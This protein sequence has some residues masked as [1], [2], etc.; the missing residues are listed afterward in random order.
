MARYSLRLTAPDGNYPFNIVRVTLTRNGGQSVWNATFTPLARTLDRAF[1]LDNGNWVLKVSG[2]GFIPVEE[3]FQVTGPDINKAVS[4]AVAYFTL[5]TDRDR[6]GVV[7]PD[8]GPINRSNPPAITFGTAGVGAIIPVNCNSD[9]SNTA[10]GYADNQDKN[11]NGNNDRDHDIAHMQIKLV[12]VGANDPISPDWK[13]RL[14][15]KN[16]GI[17]T[18]PPQQHFRVFNGIANNSTEILG[19]ETDFETEIKANTLGATKSYGIEAVRFAGN[20]FRRGDGHIALEVIQ[21]EVTGP[22]VRSYWFSEK[23]VAARWIGNHHLQTP[24]DLYVAD[25]GNLAFRTALGAVAL[26]DGVTVNLADPENATPTGVP[27]LDVN[28]WRDDPDSPLANDDDRWLR[29]TIVSG[30]TAWPGNNGAVEEKQVFMKT[31]RLRP[32]QNWVY[33]TLLSASVGVTYPAAGSRNDHLN[34]GNSGGNIGVTPPVKK[35]TNAGTTEYLYGRI[36]YGD[37]VYS[38]VNFS[39]RAFF[40]A[41]NMQAAIALDTDWLSVGHVD[42]MMTFVPYAAGANAFKKWKLLIASPKAAYDLMT[43]NQGAHGA[44]KVMQRPAWNTGTS[45]FGYT[46][47]RIGGTSVACTINDLLGNGNAPLANP[48]GSGAYTYAQLRNWNLNGIEQVIGRNVSLL[49]DAFDLDDSDIIRVPVIFYPCHQ[50]DENRPT[51][52][53]DFI[54]WRVGG[55][56]HGFN[57]FPGKNNGFRTGALTA[58]MPNMFVGN[59]RLYVPKPFGPWIEA[60]GHDMAAARDEDKNGY[61]L[62]EQDLKTKLATA[63]VTHTCV[64][65]DDWNDYHVAHG[66]IHCGTNE[67]RTPYDGQTAFGAARYEDWWTAVDA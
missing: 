36:Y 64:F 11:V 9:G 65:I 50:I 44:A 46:N 31:F 25:A 3:A 62:F 28:T 38:R 4:L 29:D 21:P 5:H 39:T 17:G 2:A 27:Y 20:G 42:E 1:D 26:A 23:I 35:T 60:P 67:L 37:N 33:E 22:S 49:K 13:L 14:S 15:L 30:H 63:G 7:D 61:D 34:D 12:R 18:A 8:A 54:S 40:D 24:T 16:N 41:Q 57:V 59:N 45:T 58:D 55:D 32:L 10:P 56:D 19:P 53:N 52:I 66:E 6:D 51:L 43:T 47:L 48:D